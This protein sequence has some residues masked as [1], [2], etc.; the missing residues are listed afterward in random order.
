MLEPWE[1]EPW[2]EPYQAAIRESDRIKI[3]N[4]IEVARKAIN[5]RIAELWCSST[6][7]HNNKPELGALQDALNVL[8]LLEKQN[9]PKKPLE[10]RIARRNLFSLC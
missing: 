2:A 1:K 3:S 7:R 4:R 5:L 9:A 10:I 6:R 8:R